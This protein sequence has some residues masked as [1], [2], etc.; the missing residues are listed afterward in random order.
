MV[1]PENLRWSSKFKIYNAIVIRTIYI[2][3]HAIQNLKQNTGGRSHNRYYL[4]NL[5]IMKNVF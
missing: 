4:Y 3:V 5:Y 1:K 2:V